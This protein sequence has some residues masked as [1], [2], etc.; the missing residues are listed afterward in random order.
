MWSS[1]QRWK[2][3]IVVAFPPTQTRSKSTVKQQD[4]RIQ[5][6]DLYSS[7]KPQLIYGASA[8]VTECK[9]KSELSSKVLDTQLQRA[10]SLGG[11]QSMRSFPELTKEI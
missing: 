1:S 5:E 3:N 9:G 6:L 4:F 7:A 2:F 10:S 8:L 11:S